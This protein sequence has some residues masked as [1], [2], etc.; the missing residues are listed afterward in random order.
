MKR[1]A[2]ATLMTLIAAACGNDAAKNSNA[3]SPVPAAPSAP[4]VT[5]ITV[6]IATATA[7]SFQLTAMA[8]LSD[9][10][11]ENVTNT[12]AWDSSNPT[13]ASVSNGGLVTAVTAGEA[14]IHA[15]Y[16]SI[17]GAF[18]LKVVLPRA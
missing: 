7:S 13:V 2:F 3:P 1:L 16:R 14:E 11:T 17:V 5:G 9:G 15:T 8:R 6:N 10:E 4:A 12:A 18:P